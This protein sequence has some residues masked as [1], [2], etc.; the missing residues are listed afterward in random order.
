LALFCQTLEQA[1]V[2]TV[3]QGS[4]TKDLAMLVKGSGNVKEGSDYLVTEAFME[5]I[6]MNFQL[7]WSKIMA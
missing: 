5:K 6:D 1:V 7:E 4:M 3:E 2:T